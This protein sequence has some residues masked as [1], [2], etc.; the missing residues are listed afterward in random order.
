MIDME[1][2]HLLSNTG[3]GAAA[4]TI[5]QTKDSGGY[6]AR[7]YHDSHLDRHLDHGHNGC[8][9]SDDDESYGRDR[10][11]GGAGGRREWE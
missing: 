5:P 1:D 3:S 8:K 2:K 6:S 7:I 10:E 9:D 11:E 4:R